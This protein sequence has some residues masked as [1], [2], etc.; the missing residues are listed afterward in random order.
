MQ[1]LEYDILVNRYFGKK[2]TKFSPSNKI[3]YLDRAFSPNPT[4]DNRTFSLDTLMLEYSS[5]GLGDFRTSS[6]EVTGQHGSAIDLKYKE[7]R[8]FTGKTELAA[9]PASHAE[10]HQVETLEIDLYDQVADLTI[11]LS[12]SVFEEANFLSGS[13]KITFLLA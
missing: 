4:S 5:N 9:L 7:H 1:V 12:Y 2:I 3:S 10:D 8:I 6:I 13:A 11:T